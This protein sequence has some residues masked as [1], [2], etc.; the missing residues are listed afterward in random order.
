MATSNPLL[1]PKSKIVAVYNK[2]RVDRGL[3]AINEVDFEFSNPVPYSGIKSTKN[4]RIYL[5]PRANSS[6]IGRITVYYDRINLSTVV[7]AKVI[8]GT[9][10]TVSQ[11]L[12]EINEELGLSVS[13]GL[14][15]TKVL[16]KVA[17]NWVK[18]NGLTIIEVATTNEFLAK[19]PIGKVWGIGPQTAECPG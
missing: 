16:A 6:Q 13:I 11:L 8:R 14:A 3:P 5:T 1:N 15:P 17:S 9:A 12:T 2:V 4:T 19:V 18:P 7:G 10:T